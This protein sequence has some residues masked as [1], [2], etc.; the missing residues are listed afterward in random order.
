MPNWAFFLGRLA[1]GVAGSALMTWGGWKLGGS[2]WALLGFVFSTPL[3]GVA[4]AKPLVEMTEDGIGWLS[5]QPLKKW[6]RHYYEFGGVQVRVFEDGGELWFAADD[7]IKAAGIAAV[8]GALP[9]SKLIPEIGLSCMAIDGV[10]G[11]LTRHRS[12]EAGR[13]M[14]WARREVVAPWERKRSGALVPR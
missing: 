12:P 3:I 1:L 9:E 10:E 7:V 8:G 2:T 14:L 6:E 11:L 4:I 13:F 5:A